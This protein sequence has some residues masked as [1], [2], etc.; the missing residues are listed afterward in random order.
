MW[1]VWWQRSLRAKRTRFSRWQSRRNPIY[2]T[3]HSIALMLCRRTATICRARSDAIP[4]SPARS[5]TWHI[6]V[7]INA[8]FMWILNIFALCEMLEIVI[9]CLNISSS[10][11]QTE[12]SRCFFAI[13]KSTNCVEE[14]KRIV[15]H[16]EGSHFQQA[17]FSAFLLFFFFLVAQL[18]MKISVRFLTCISPRCFIWVFFSEH[19]ISILS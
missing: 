1:H 18:Q 11:E 6:K 10:H 13:F 12:S 5:C 7:S 2:T 15:S 17:S 16:E 8:F 3:P 4:A 14:E 9:L 19:K